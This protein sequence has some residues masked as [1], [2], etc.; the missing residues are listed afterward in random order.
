MSLEDQDRTITPFPEGLW[1]QP[2]PTVPGDVDGEPIQ[3]IRVPASIRYEYIPGKATTRFLRALE[4]KQIIGERTADTG[5]VYVPPRG[6]SPTT[7]RPTVEQVVLANKGTVSTFCIVHI[8]FG[9]N[10]PPTPF[11]TAMV[12]LDGASVSVYG[13]IQEIAYDQVHIGQRVE[14]VWVDDDQ[15][16]TSFEN[17]KYW[18]P[19]DEPDVAPELLKG[20]M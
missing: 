14:A 18:R 4:R 12:L 15:L 2:Q 7:G 16:S 13:P 9:V 17:I 3:R 19:I 11:V 20:H 5:E 6:T 1:A 8:G 10:A